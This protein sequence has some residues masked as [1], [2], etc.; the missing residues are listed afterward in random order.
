MA[1][2][3]IEVLPLRQSSSRAL[4]SA[5]PVIASRSMAVPVRSSKTGADRVQLELLRRADASRRF[6]LARSLSASA[7]SLAR[8]AMRRGRPD[9]SEREILL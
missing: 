2:I 7:I 5:D 1:R 6:Q 9:L 4:T 8:G 3:V